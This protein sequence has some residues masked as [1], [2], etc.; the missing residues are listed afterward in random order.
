MIFTLSVSPALHSLF[1]I[2]SYFDLF[3]SETRNKEKSTEGEKREHANHFPHKL[4]Q[5][6]PFHPFLDE[7][8]NIRRG[9]GSEEL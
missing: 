6:S 8:R 7:G 2:D 4:S 3:N 1:S 5:I 9:V